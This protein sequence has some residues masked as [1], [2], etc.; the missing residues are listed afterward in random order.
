MSTWGE[1]QFLSNDIHAWQMWTHYLIC[2]EISNRPKALA[3]FS[4]DNTVEYSVQ[5]VQKAAMQRGTATLQD[6]PLGWRRRRQCSR[7]HLTTREKGV[8]SKKAH[9]EIINVPPLS[10]PLGCFNSCCTY[11]CLGRRTVLIQSH[12]SNLA[13]PFD[14]PN[15]VELTL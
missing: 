7:A 2:L 15:K 12:C 5:V 4:S 8:H 13:G 10:L 3:C 6:T 11:A 14:S 9:I 1:A